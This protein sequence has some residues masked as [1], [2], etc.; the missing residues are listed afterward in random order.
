MWFLDGKLQFIYLIRKRDKVAVLMFK[1]KWN[2]SRN[3]FPFEKIILKNE[4][5]EKIK[6]ERNILFS[7]SFSVSFYY[8]ISGKYKTVSLSQP[9]VK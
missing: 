1:K 6:N 9:T 8:I 2:Q 7:I 4:L 3:F 5:K